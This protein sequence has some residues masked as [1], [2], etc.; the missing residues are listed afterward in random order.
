MPSTVGHEDAG[1]FLNG[2]D[3]LSILVD[4]QVSPV[5]EFFD[6]VGLGLRAAVPLRL[7]VV[8]EVAVQANDTAF[9]DSEGVRLNVTAGDVAEDKRCRVHTH[10]FSIE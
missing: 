8:R 2:E 1:L 3:V 7:V 9:R 4:D 10:G 5:P 6:G